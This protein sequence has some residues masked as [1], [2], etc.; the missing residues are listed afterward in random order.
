[1]KSE[2]ISNAKRKGE[3]NRNNGNRY[4]AWAFIEAAHFGI[5]WA[6]KIKAYY[7]RKRA[8]RRLMV[9][10]K[11]VANKLARATYRHRGFSGA[12]V[13]P[14]AATAVSLRHRS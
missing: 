10:R 8:S 3:G 7:Q 6:P 9:A 14:G 11:A 13:P 12:A 1:M 5:I 4:L 2:R